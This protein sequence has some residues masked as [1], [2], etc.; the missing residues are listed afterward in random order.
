[1]DFI[2]VV[3]EKVGSGI[4]GV[5]SMIGIAL[6]IM[7]GMGSVISWPIIG[8]YLIE[9]TGGDYSLIIMLVVFLIFF[10]IAFITALPGLLFVGFAIVGALMMYISG[11]GLLWCMAGAFIGA[12]MATIPALIIGLLRS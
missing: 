11:S 7:F 12:C 1:M 6:V 10:V 4:G 5:F 9:P 3:F 2:I 8:K